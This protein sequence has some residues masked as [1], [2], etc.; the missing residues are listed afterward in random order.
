M[1]EESLDLG[2][3]PGLSAKT[4]CKTRKQKRVEERGREKRTIV[5]SVQIISTTTNNES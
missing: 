5:A 2:G 4:N 3:G 1:C